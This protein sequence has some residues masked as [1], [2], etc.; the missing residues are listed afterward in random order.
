MP[1]YT[2][3]GM[4]S[5]DMTVSIRLIRKDFWTFRSEVEKCHKNIGLPFKVTNESA[6]RFKKDI[7]FIKI[8]ISDIFI[9][10]FNNLCKINHFLF[11]NLVLQRH[12]IV[13]IQE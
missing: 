9:L 6:L 11:L 4:R 13:E 12:K 8:N 2:G 3:R 1:E 7:S 5:K 10:R